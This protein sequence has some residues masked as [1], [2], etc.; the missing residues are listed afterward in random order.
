MRYSKG[1]KIYLGAS[2]A[3][4]AKACSTLVEVT[5]DAIP[6]I[7]GPFFYVAP[8]GSNSNDGSEASP[9]ANLS[10][11]CG[12]VQTAGAGIV[13][14]AGTYSDNAQCVLRPKVS[15]VGAGKAQVTIIAGGR[16][17]VVN[18]DHDMVEG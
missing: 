6:P 13:L 1:E 8:N 10:Y 12:R 2:A 15:I 3:G 14:K 9:W 5:D 16:V 17:Q 4:L 18:S 11:A 7:P